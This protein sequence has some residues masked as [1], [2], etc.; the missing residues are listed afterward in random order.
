MSTLSQ[1][2]QL[3][4]A[5]KSQ[6]WFAPSMF[7]T[8]YG[9]WGVKI[10]VQAYRHNK[11]GSIETCGYNVDGPNYKKAKADFWKQWNAEHKGE[12]LTI[13]KGIGAYGL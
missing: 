11:D 12:Y 3:K 7:I 1:E 4:R 8:F 9:P 2:E 13:L 5:Q 10:E 6:K